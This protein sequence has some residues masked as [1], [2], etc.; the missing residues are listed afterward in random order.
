MLCRNKAYSYESEGVTS[1]ISHNEN[2][3]RFGPFSANLNEH[4]HQ[5]PIQVNLPPTDNTDHEKTMSSNK[6]HNDC[7][8]VAM[9]STAKN[10]VTS[11]FIDPRLLIALRS[12]VLYEDLFGKYEQLLNMCKNYISLFSTIRYLIET[13]DDQVFCIVPLSGDILS[14][15]LRCRIETCHESRS[16]LHAILAVS[17][18]HSGRRENK[19]DYSTADANDHRNTA[20]TLYRRELDAF[21]DL[22]QGV[23][24]LDTTM[25]LFLFKVSH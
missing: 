20:E 13:T 24:L 14:N 19:N 2:N 6:D 1:L 18:Y 15:P 12:P 10:H 3:G 7:G 21:T 16:L 8:T 23:R 22:P 4:S 9:S 5:S 17:C 25:I 11:M